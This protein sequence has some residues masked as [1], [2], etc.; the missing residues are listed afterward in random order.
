MLMDI[1]RT[2]RTPHII[3]KDN[4][5]SFDSLEEVSK[6]MDVMSNLE[7]KFESFEKKIAEDIALVLAK[8]ETLSN[9]EQPPES[10]QFT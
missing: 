2:W 4:L 5:R 3:L 7:P 1:I 9:K 10:D 6:Q 8:L